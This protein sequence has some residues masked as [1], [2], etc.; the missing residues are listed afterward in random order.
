MQQPAHRTRRAGRLLGLGLAAAV[1]LI[2]PR[3]ALAGAPPQVSDDDPRAPQVSALITQ[4][5]LL[6]LGM[7]TQPEP[8]DYELAYQMLE[9]ASALDPTNL[10]LR[11]QMVAAAWGTTNQDRLTEATRRV[12]ELDPKDTVAQLRLITS[13][14]ARQQTV[15]ERLTAYDRFLGRE[16][17]N[18]D[19]S[20][21]SRLALDAAL[22]AR[23]LGDEDGFVRRLSLSTTLDM[24]NKEA[25][26]MAAAF[27]AERR[28]VPHEQLEMLVNLLY[29]DPIDPNVHDTIARALA[30]QGAYLQAKRFA[31]DAS[32]IRRR[33]GGGSLELAE[34][35]LMYIWHTDGPQAVVD[36]LNKQLA[37]QRSQAAV[38][39]AIAKAAK[40]PALD[41][42]PPEEIRLDPTFDRLRILAAEVIGDTQTRDAAI[43]DMS[44]GAEVTVRR[45]VASVGSTDKDAKI[46][47]I[48]EMANLFNAIHFVRALIGYKPEES[49]GAFQNFAS[50]APEIRI[51]IS[52]LVPWISLRLDR[53]DMAED[54]ASLVRPP[55]AH[56]LLQ[57]EIAMAK[58]DKE[59][60]KR[61]YLEVVRAAPITPIGCWAHSKLDQLGAASELL[62]PDGRR[63]ATF[64]DSVDP[65]IDRVCRDTLDFE[66]LRVE[67]VKTT[68]GATERATIHVRLQNVAPIPLAL[69]SGRPISSRLLV[70]PKL[71]TETG[72]FQGE[73]QPLVLDLDRR[74]RLMPLEVLEATIPADSPFTQWLLDV[75]AGATMRERWRVLQGFRAVGEQGSMLPGALCLSAETR[76]SVVRLALPTADLPPSELA[77]RLRD[78]PRDTLASTLYGIRALL[79]SEDPAKSESAELEDLVEAIIERYDRSDLLDRSLMLLVVPH[80]RLNK[81]VVPFESAVR[82]SLSDRMQAGDPVTELEVS[83]ILFT[84]AVGTEDPLLTYLVSSSSPRVSS[85]A[86]LLI[87]RYA[88]KGFGYANVGPDLNTIAGP[89]IGMLRRRIDEVQRGK[90]P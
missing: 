14:I 19:P 28:Q 57:A 77:R 30:E 45:L 9:Y 24:T 43:A 56:A 44:A 10:E 39:L 86:S 48:Q 18:L 12:L 53:I 15:E 72:D 52:N 74:L 82:K 73:P 13:M 38:N 32:I 11:H 2:V 37:I 55:D 68:I 25:A 64:A 60:A 65:L 34:R 42:K 80:A 27:H 29:A 7:Q 5:T 76:D 6:D 89:T 16:G 66:A 23:E 22:L 3:P 21:R 46:R 20:V 54:Q 63:M 49:A 87:E 79:L 85:I 81:A 4:L 8:R 90:Q 35:D 70:Q 40:L 33:S 1:A 71:D 62:T 26:T 58:G 47:A 50:I 41:L 59:E 84:R 78:D 67:A 36:A 83:L 75:N 61:L 31:N 17:E 88:A 51:A 69:G